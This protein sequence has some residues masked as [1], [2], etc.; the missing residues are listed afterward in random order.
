MIGTGYDRSIGGLEITK[1]MRDHLLE[2]W[3]KIEKTEKPLKENP[4]AMAKLTAEAERVKQ[5]SKWEWK[6]RCMNTIN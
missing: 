4:R 6:N 3:E 1:R 5:V 2:K